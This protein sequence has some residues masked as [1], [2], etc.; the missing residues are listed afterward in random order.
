MKDCWSRLECLAWFL[1]FKWQVWWCIFDKG[2]NVLQAYQI[3]SLAEILGTFH[4]KNN[5]VWNFRNSTCPM[6][7]YI[8]VAQ[9]RSISHHTFEYC[10]C[11]SQACTIYR[12]AALGTTIDFCQMKRDIP[13]W[14]TKMTGPVKVDHLHRWSQIFW[15]DQSKMVCFILIS[16]QNIQNFWG[17]RRVPSQTC[18]LQPISYIWSH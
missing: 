10:V 15:L 2:T 17:K 9:S 4:S 12:W 14:M 8:P 18:T 16:N 5:P 1:N 11:N 7:G 3:T 6:E 13:V